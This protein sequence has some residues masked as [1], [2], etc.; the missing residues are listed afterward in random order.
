L[1]Q[2]GYDESVLVPE[3]AARFLN[4][5]KEDLRVGLSLP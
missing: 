3:S 1:A 4:A 5:I 2:H